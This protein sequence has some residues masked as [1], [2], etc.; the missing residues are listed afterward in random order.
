MSV[1]QFC[2]SIMHLCLITE[3]AHKKYSKVIFDLRSTQY[4]LHLAIAT[5]AFCK[6][7][8]GGGGGVKFENSVMYY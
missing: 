6:A 1:N 2:N 5:V 7:M 8:C 4:F 3:I